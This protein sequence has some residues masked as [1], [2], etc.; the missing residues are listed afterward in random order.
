[1]E[2]INP[3]A[4][5][6]RREPMAT[7]SRNRSRGRRG[8]ESGQRATIGKLDQVRRVLGLDRRIRVENG[9]GQVI[10]AAIGECGQIRPDG[11]TQAAK[12]MAGC[13]DAS[14]RLRAGR[15]IALQRQ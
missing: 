13:T 4:G 10:A 15:W 12:G 8:D 14:K 11:V 2:S 7:G 3:A 5:S 9:G 6:P 1:M